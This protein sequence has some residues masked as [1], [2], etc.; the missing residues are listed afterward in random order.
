MF[1]FTPC[2]DEPFGLVAIEAM[3]CGLPVAAFDAGAAREVVG[4]AGCIAPAG[5]V[6]A[7]ADALT[8]AMAIPR[9]TA[10]CRVETHFARD[11]WL[12]RC[13]ALYASVRSALP[14]AIAA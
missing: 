14:S 5:D 9:S 8:R 6:S 1:L 12:D 3:A 11:L 13:E 4:E 2:W 10:R 7:L